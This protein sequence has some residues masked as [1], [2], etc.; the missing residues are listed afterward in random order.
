MAEAVSL[1]LNN[2]TLTSPGTAG[3]LFATVIEVGMVGPG[4]R[5]PGRCFGFLPAAINDGS[6]CT[7]PLRW[8]LFSSHRR[9][10][11]NFDHTSGMR[12]SDGARP[13][14]PVVSDRIVG[15][16][17]HFGGE[18]PTCRPAS[19]GQPPVYPQAELVHLARFEPLA[20]G[21]A[22]ARMAIGWVHYLA[23][24][25]L[26][27]AR[28]V[29]LQA[30]GNAD[31][32][33]AVGKVLQGPGDASCATRPR[34]QLAGSQGVWHFLDTPVQFFALIRANPNTTKPL[35]TSSSLQTEGIQPSFAGARNPGGL[36]SD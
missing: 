17:R 7:R 24:I 33:S 23:Q 20:F 18:D 30:G 19:I 27:Q 29:R 3:W 16:R 4:P 34:P 31:F 2:D 6:V 8:R 12:T 9:Y 1:F 10:R 5:R 13:S 35:A 26:Q 15:T 11:R 22:S 25:R 21:F 36:H 14:R 28:D 32:A